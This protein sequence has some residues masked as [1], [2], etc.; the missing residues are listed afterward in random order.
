MILRKIVFYS[1][2]NRTIMLGFNDTQWLLN[3]IF[4]K[5]IIRIIYYV[6]LYFLGI[7]KKFWRFFKYFET[8]NS[9]LNIF[10]GSDDLAVFP[11]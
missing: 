3:Q 4:L 8:T 5:W 7:Y 2:E 1:L 6:N 9:D 11:G 10:P